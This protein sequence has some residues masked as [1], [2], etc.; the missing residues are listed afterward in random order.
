M[1][2]MC[3]SHYY[4]GINHIYKMYG[5]RHK[6]KIQDELCTRAWEDDILLFQ[7]K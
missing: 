5:C 4:R 6:G 1:I 3:A 7:Q 2:D